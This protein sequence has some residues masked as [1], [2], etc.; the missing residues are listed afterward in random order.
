[1]S[2]VFGQSDVEGFSDNSKVS[3]GDKFQCWCILWAYSPQALGFFNDF[4]TVSV[5]HVHH[6]SLLPLDNLDS[7]LVVPLV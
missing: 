3:C 1:M 2:P 7:V 6:L 5:I 4:D